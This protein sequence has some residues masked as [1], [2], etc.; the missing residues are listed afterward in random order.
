MAMPSTSQLTDM[1]SGSVSS[2]MIQIGLMTVFFFFFFFLIIYTH[3]L[4]DYCF[5]NILNNIYI[6]F[7]TLVSFKK[8]KTL[9]LCFIHIIVFCL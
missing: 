7:L 8:F 4:F 2:M 3:L 6:L 1:M 5:F 9:S